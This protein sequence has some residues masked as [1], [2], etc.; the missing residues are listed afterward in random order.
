MFHVKHFDGEGHFFNF[1][2]ILV[3]GK[4]LEDKLRQMMIKDKPAMMKIDTLL[5]V[6]MG[7]ALGAMMRVMLCRY[8]PPFF[9]DS[10][11]VPIFLVNVGGCFMMGAFIELLGSLWTPPPLLKDFLTT[12]FLGGFTT[13][14]AFSLEYALLVE[15]GLHRGALIYAF[16]T[17][18]G[19]LIAFFMGGK[20]VRFLLSL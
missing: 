13:F 10:F 9:G 4:H 16:A 2:L 19:T 18:G 6:G 3:I 7:G 20:F 8:L 14:S 1:L 11:P 12:G 5:A 15:K 17:F